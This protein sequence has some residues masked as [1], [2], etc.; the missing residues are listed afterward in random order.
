LAGLGLLYAPA[1]YSPKCVEWYFSEVRMQDLA[2]ARSN[3]HERTDLLQMLL[4]NNTPRS[5]TA[6]PAAKGRSDRGYA[7]FPNFALN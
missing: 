1:L 5:A 7:G 6:P 3:T 2:W 4:T